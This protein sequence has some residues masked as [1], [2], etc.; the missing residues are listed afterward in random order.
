[1]PETAKHR[2]AFDIYWRLGSE[3]S[4][5]RLHADLSEAGAA[6]T[7]RTLYEWSSRYHWQDRLLDLERQARRVED[8]ARIAALREMQDRQTKEGLLLQQKGAEWL[9]KMDEKR[10][11]ADAAT[12]AITE[13]ARLERLARGEVTERQEVRNGEEEASER[14]AQFT[15]EEIESLIRRAEGLVDGEGAEESG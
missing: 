5:E 13:G 1:M 7:L 10:V 15:D 14:L 6:P 12:R 8:E 2:H 11:T 4:V 3:R 9:S